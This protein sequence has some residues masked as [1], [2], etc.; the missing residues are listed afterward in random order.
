MNKYRHKTNEPYPRAIIFCAQ[1][2]R[3]L[4][5][6]EDNYS[7]GFCSEHIASHKLP[8]PRAGWGDYARLY[9]I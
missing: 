2:H 7:S 6:M 4:E 8:A 9:V 1:C 5:I 3:F